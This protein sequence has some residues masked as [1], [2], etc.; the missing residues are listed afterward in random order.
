MSFWRHPEWFSK[1][2]FYYYK[3]LTPIIAKK[4]LHILTVSEFSR[5]E[6]I[7]CL[8]IDGNKISVIYNAV[9]HNFISKKTDDV[10]YNTYDYIL[11]VSSIDPRKNF[12]R[13]LSGVNLLETNIKLVIIGNTNNVFQNINLEL[14]SRVSYL[15][16]VSDEELKFYYSNAKLFVYPS[17]YE[18]FGLPPLEAMAMGCPT[19]VSDIEVFHEVFDTAVEYFNPYDIND[20]ATCIEYVLS[21]KVIREGLIFKGFKQIEKYCWQ[22][23]ASK[24]FAVINKHK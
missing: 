18:G 6:I 1:L 19:I 14:S 16:H 2:Y 3:F 22:M 24:L 21:S 20:I 11:A 7:E 8:K 5:K 17:V 12:S 15:G 23:S 13:L 10:T 4:A 9:S